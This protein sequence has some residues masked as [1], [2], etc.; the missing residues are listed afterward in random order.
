MCRQGLTFF[1]NPT[2]RFNPE[3]MGKNG[4]RIQKQKEKRYY[5]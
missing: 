1:Q 4:E 5:F 3:F 2:F